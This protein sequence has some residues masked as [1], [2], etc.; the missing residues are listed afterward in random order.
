MSDTV[1]Q[2]LND[3]LDTL[4]TLNITIDGKS[5]TCQTGEYLIDIA[6]RN[7]I[8]IPTLCGKQEALRGRGCCRVCIVELIER[9][10]SK[11]VV[12]CVY[13]VERECEVFT[14]SD[15][16]ERI[17]GTVFAL[18]ENLA[19]SSQTITQ[20]ATAYKAPEIP[21]LKANP[22]GGKCILCGLCV[23][24]CNDLGTGAIA[25]VNRGVSKMIDTPLGKP[26]AACIACGSCAS[27]CPTGQIEVEQTADTYKI[28]NQ[29][30]E[31]AKCEVCGDVLG[32][33]KS[34][35]HAAKLTGYEP[36]TRCPNHRRRKLADVIARSQG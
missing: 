1:S 18:L 34:L 3:T 17:R 19:P 5:C 12:S 31:L 32:T 22:E 2:N 23:E 28:W 16:V 24:A 14:K 29:T 8:F 7:G 36:E 25:A 21:R 6:K 33:K 27:I 13:P 30:F 20:M 10:R 35:E 11:M 9:G 4:N 26:A 15:K